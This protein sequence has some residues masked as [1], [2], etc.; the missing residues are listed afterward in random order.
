[1]KKNVK[2]CYAQRKAVESLPTGH[3]YKWGNTYGNATT[4]DFHGIGRCACGAEVVVSHS[5]AEPFRL[6][7][8]H[9]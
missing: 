6:L 9:S 5:K 3:S 1:M 4:V 7:K 8:G 2:L